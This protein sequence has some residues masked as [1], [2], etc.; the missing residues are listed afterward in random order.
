MFKTVPKDSVTGWIPF[1]FQYHHSPKIRQNASTFIVNVEDDDVGSDD[2]IGVKDKVRKM[3]DI[4]TYTG[5][6]D[7]S[8]DE[9]YRRGDFYTL[10]Y[11]ID[12]MK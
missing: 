5:Q 12:E 1:E 10:G 8:Y 11:W 2:V 4:N 3:I 7:P 6:S 9:Q